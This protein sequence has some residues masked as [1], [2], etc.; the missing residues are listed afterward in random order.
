MSENL[1]I[2]MDFDEITGP[3]P[4]YI[5]LY[6]EIRYRTPDKIAEFFR[7]F[8]VKYQRG[9]NGYARSDVWNL[10]NY[11]AEI[12]SSSVNDLRKE[13]HGYPPDLSGPDEWDVILDKI[14]KGFGVY[15]QDNN[16]W[17]LTYEEKKQRDEA[18][19]LFKE[20]FDYLW[21]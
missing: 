13:T 7:S 10:N 6:Y 4:W 15:I 20:Y 11:L 12:I 1:Y 21:D 3:D 5:N 2:T 17:T 8:R 16:I 19:E 14:S 9:M 18:F